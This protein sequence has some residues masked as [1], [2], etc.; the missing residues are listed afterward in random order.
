MPEDLPAHVEHDALARVLQGVNLA[1][2]EPKAQKEEAQENQGQ[3]AKQPILWGPEPPNLGSGKGFEVLL[4]DGITGGCGQEEVRILEGDCGFPGVQGDQKPAP[5]QSPGAL[6]LPHKVAGQIR[7]PHKVPAFFKDYC[8]R[9]RRGG[10]AD[11]HPREHQDLVHRDLGDIRKGELDH[12]D[13]TAQKEG[14]GKERPIGPG[15]PQKPAQKA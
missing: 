3:K 7:L 6:E 11:L 8:P 1:I 4:R 15:I 9:Q 5:A 14:Q 13:P 12:G 2:G 10:T